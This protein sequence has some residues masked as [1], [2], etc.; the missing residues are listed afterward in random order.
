[1]DDSENISRVILATGND[2]YQ[3]DSMSEFQIVSANYGEFCLLH[4]IIYQLDFI[5]RRQ[6]R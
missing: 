5:N 3:R 1:M 2:N 6:M 4:A